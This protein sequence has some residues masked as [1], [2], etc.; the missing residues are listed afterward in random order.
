ML[1]LESD[2]AQ[3]AREPRRLGA[4]SGF[5]PPGAVFSRT[6]PRMSRT[7]TGGFLACTTD[8]D[9]PC[10]RDLLLFF[11]RHPRAVLTSDRLALYV[12]YE[13]SAVATSLNFL[14]AKGLVTRV[15]RPTTSVLMF[16][17]T[18]DSQGAHQS[19]AHASTGNP[20]ARDGVMTSSLLLETV[21]EALRGGRLCVGCLARSCGISALRVRSA[22]A[23]IRRQAVTAEEFGRCAGCGVFGDTHATHS[24]ATRPVD[25]SGSAILVVD[26]HED[27]VD[28]YA[29]V[30]EQAG[31][32]VQRATNLLEALNLCEQVE[33]DVVVTDIAMPGASGWDVFR[34]VRMRAPSVP[35]VAVTGQLVPNG[36]ALVDQGFAAAL[37]KPIDPAHLAAV[38]GYLIRHERRA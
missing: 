13:L 35:I 23:E 26:D 24:V 2:A 25:L 33:I 10:A 9:D 34:E 32:I 36:R 21:F 22:L 11:Y 6:M 5:R 37:L 29:A 1:R 4:R 16:V 7:P 27:T 38:V 12:G 8:I 18:L 20:R 19:S 3:K 17:L 15:E 30:L 31:A 14:S 28:L